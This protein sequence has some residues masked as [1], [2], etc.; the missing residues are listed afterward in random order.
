M[1]VYNINKRTFENLFINYH[2][3]HN[4]IHMHIARN[5]IGHKE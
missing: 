5:F 3:I 4:G 2:I 1:H